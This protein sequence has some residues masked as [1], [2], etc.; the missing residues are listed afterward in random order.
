A[1]AIHEASHAVTAHL[2]GAHRRIDMVAIEKRAST[3][4]M[5][6][7]MGQEERFTQWR[8][9]METDIMVSLASLAGERLFFAGDNSSGVSGDL[10]SASTVAALMEGSYG[11][12]QSLSST[13]NTRETGAGGPANP[14][15]TALNERR[16]EIEAGLEDLYRRVGELLEE[17]QDKVLELAAVLEEK[18]TIS[19]EEVSEIMGSPPGSRAMREPRGWQ[20]VSDEMAGERQR[21]ALHRSGRQVVA[22]NNPQ[23]V[24]IEE[25]RR[26]D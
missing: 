21:A 18:K 16:A 7:S 1:V 5:V 10:S 11:M 8:S 26:G 19:G 24:E 4:G 25:T 12:G 17:H 13:M 6:K 20:A 3:L 2:L 14:V 9:E 15:S 23:A 22:S